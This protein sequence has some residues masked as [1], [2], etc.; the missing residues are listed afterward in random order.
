MRRVLLVETL[1]DRCVPAVAFLGPPVH[2]DPGGIAIGL[3]TETEP[4]DSIAQANPI[5]LMPWPMPMGAQMGTPMPNPA[6]D[7]APPNGAS[8][9][10][11]TVQPPLKVLLDKVEAECVAVE[12]PRSVDVIGGHEGDQVSVTEHFS[13]AHAS[14]LAQP[15]FAAMPM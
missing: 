9:S 11:L 2:S 4:N 1:E 10:F 5:Q 14:V 3:P 8:G 6:G 12:L 15:P 13:S 7:A